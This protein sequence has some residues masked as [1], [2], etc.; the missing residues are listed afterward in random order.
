MNNFPHSESQQNVPGFDTFHFADAST[1]G[2][3]TIAA[4][5]A[6]VAPSMGGA[7][8]YEGYVTDGKLQIKVDP[9]LTD[10]GTH[11][12][13]SIQGFIPKHKSVTQD[14]FE[15]MLNKYFNVI[16]R[17]KNG[18]LVYYGASNLGGLS[19]SYQTT[20]AGYNYEFNGAQNF[21]PPFYTANIPT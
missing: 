8:F 7:V 2:A 12:E 19:F 3:L 13:V 15:E 5:V 10:N 4:N 9:K 11:Y 16:A 20:E 1:I 6:S 17:D 18:K 21:A 14:L